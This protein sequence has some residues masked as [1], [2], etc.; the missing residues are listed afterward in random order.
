MLTCTMCTNGIAELVAVE[1]QHKYL[2]T[3]PMIFTMMVLQ[4]LI[5]GIKSL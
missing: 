5:Y 2:D 3:C 4:L 1:K